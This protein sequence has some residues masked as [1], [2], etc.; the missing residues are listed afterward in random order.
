[1]LV[2]SLDDEVGRQRRARMR[3]SA[4]WLMSP[5]VRPENVPDH[6]KAHWYPGR[7]S[8]ARNERLQGA[9][10]AHLRAWETLAAMGSPPCVILE[11][12]AVQLRPL[13]DLGKHITL[14][15]GVFAGYGHWNDLPKYIASREYIL[16]LARLRDGV[17][18]LPQRDG[19]RMRWYM[20]VAYYL[21]KGAAMR[22]V[23]EVKAAKGKVLKSPDNWLNAFVTHFAWPP[24]FGDQGAES[25]C[26]SSRGDGGS[27]LYCNRRMLRYI[28]SNSSG[29]VAREAAT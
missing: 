29:A 18:P 11:D 24:P 10:S 23:S 16:E 21:P 19:V 9:F 20:A 15:G 3:L 13:P 2:I 1:M 5:G 12:D 14:L 28:T 26:L 6:V 7:Y 22:L 8:K 4:P 27:D 25:Q 17:Q